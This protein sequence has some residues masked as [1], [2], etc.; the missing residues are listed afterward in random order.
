MS[1]AN[2]SLFAISDDLLALDNILDDLGGDVSDEQV[3]SI[4]AE[5]FE[6]LGEE[7]DRKLDNYA[8][9]IRELEARAEA[10]KVEA[11]RLAALVTIDT[12]RI[13]ALKRR[14]KW[15]FE[16]HNLPPIQTAR[17]RLS[18]AGNGGKLPLLLDPDLTADSLPEEFRKV[19]VTPDPDKIRAALESGAQLDFARLGERGKSIRI[20]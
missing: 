17:F 9:F 19:S 18:L 14:L 16:Y 3:E 12:N 8:A 5:W 7:R 1:T 13:L 2:R 6:N 20:K 10:R 11:H 4:I 15:F